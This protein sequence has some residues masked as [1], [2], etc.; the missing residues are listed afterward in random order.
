M[1]T[2]DLPC[3]DGRRSFY[4]KA[5]VTEEGTTLTLTSY[6]TDVCTL[7]RETRELV[8]LDPV[9]TATTRR[10]IRSFLEHFG[11]PQMSNDA[12]DRLPLHTIIPA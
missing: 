11:Y 5:R 9:A 3:H 7:D 6:T 2:Y 12:W 10:H 8:K 4:G 1:R